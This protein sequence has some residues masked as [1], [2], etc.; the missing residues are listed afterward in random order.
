MT[1]TKALIVG[2]IVLVILG[3]L[4][5][6]QCGETRTAETRAKLSTGQAGAAIESGGDAVDTIG[7]RMATDAAGDR[8]T[9]ENRDAIQ[10][11]EG[12]AALVAAPVRDAGLA[13]LCR[14]A[15]YRGDA[16]CVQYANPR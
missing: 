2:A 12:A 4:L 7:N 8:T 14:R 6:R 15:T 16:K 13:S 5:L 9:Q 10:N 3:A 11:V 1:R